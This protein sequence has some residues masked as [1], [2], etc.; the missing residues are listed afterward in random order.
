MPSLRL[1]LIL[2]T[3]TFA[4]QSVASAATFQGLGGDF[5]DDVSGD[6]S[7]VVGHDGQQTQNTIAWRWTAAGGKVLLPRLH[8]DTFGVRIHIWFRRRDP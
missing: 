8:A 6:G 3:T 5:A 1:S 2:M 4:V 7:T